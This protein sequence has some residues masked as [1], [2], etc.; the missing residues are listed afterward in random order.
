MSETIDDF[1]ALYDLTVIQICHLAAVRLHLI[2]AGC[3]N[4]AYRPVGE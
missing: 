3:E 2:I 1:A 4:V